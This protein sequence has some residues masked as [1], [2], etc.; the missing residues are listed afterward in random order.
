M[1]TRARIALAAILIVAA[2]FCF[3]VVDAWHV[4]AGDGIQYWQIAQQLEKRLTLAYSDRGQPAYTRLPGYPMFLAF[5]ASRA[6]ALERTADHHL[7]RATRANVLLHILTSLLIWWMLRVRNVRGEWA[8]LIATLTCPFLILLTCYGLSE[9]LA[10]FLGVL[11]VALAV[12][13]MRGDR[14]V[15]F[16]I[17]AG[18][19]AGLA[20]L[21]RAD[22]VTCAP[23]V[24]IALACANAH[25]RRRMLAIA[26]CGIAA[27]VV[28][29]PWPIRNLSQFGAMHA[30]GHQW[31]A[32]DGGA[33]PLGV[34]HWMRT[35]SASRYGEA[36]VPFKMVN[37][38][39]VDEHNLVKEMWDSEAE[40]QRVS[41]LFKKYSKEG[42][43]PAVDGEFEQLAAERRHREPWRTWVTLPSGRLVALWTPVPEYELPMRIPWLGLPAHRG[44]FG[45]W[46][47]LAALLAIVGVI[48]LARRERAFLVVAILPLVTR[49]ILHSLAVPHGVTMRYLVEA[50]PFLTLLA[51]VGIVAIVNLARRRGASTS[52]ES[53]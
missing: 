21:V 13:A 22:A 42:L 5:V 8:A 37:R 52:L 31:P 48:A 51:G 33:P 4:P 26:A 49:S 29:A 45:W 38:M 32:Q 9:T 2:A 6:A 44:A 12:R 11:E 35:W 43:T 53:R 18:V 47:A 19:A 41:A 24:L 39:P 16:A 14:L 27:G 50:V 28:F 30:E 7:E 23:S 20:Q 46:E 3:R 10:T 36:Y 40:H 15:L 17:L 1:S 34:I 25:P